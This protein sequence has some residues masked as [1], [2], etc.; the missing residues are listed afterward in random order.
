MARLEVGVGATNKELK[1]VLADSQTLVRNFSNNLQ[2]I[3]LNI[4]VNDRVN[5]RIGDTRQSLRSLSSTIREFK[6]AKLDLSVGNAITELKSL[7][8]QLAQT[9]KLYT[10]IRSVI[11]SINSTRGTSVG[12]G[13]SKAA[14]DAEKAAMAAAKREAQLLKNEYARLN[15]EL[16]D[17]AVTRAKDRASTTAASGSYREAQQ[18]LTALGRAIREQANG[19]NLNNK[20]IQ[21]QIAQYRQLNNQLK[22]FDA[23]MG[24]HQRKVG[25]YG[26]VWGGIGHQLASVAAGYLS[27]QAAINGLN[28]AFRSAIR[29]DAI[30]TSLG[31]ILNSGDLAASKLAIIRKEADRLGLSYL[32][33]AGSYKSFI[34]AAQASN[35]NMTN[36]ESIFYAVSNAAAKLKLS[37]DD[38]DGAFRALQQMISKGT[39]QAEE[40]RGQLGERLPGAFAIAARAMGVTEQQLGKM[41]KAGDV[42]ASD[43][44]PRLAVELNRTFGNDQSERIESLQASV[45]RLS[46]T[47][48][49][50][51]QKGNVSK[52]FQWIVD[53]ANEALSRVDKLVNS[54]S[55]RELVFRAN[56]L[57]QGNPALASYFNILG[58][59]EIRRGQ[60]SPQVSNNTFVEQFK[61]MNLK[62]QTKY[63]EQQ[64]KALADYQSQVTEGKSSGKYLQEQI[65]LVSMLE[66]AYKGATGGAKELTKEQIDAIERARKKQEEEAKRIADLL[67]KLNREAL[68]SG[69]EGM[70]REIQETKNKYEDLQEQAKGHAA[71]LKQIKEH[72]QRDLLAIELKYASQTPFIKNPGINRSPAYMYNDPATNAIIFGNRTGNYVPLD[73]D[74]KPKF[75]FKEISDG[76]KRASRKFVSDFTKAIDDIGDGL[77]T[78]FDTI[79]GHLGTSLLN[80]FSNIFENTLGNKLES[81]LKTRL[82]KIEKGQLTGMDGWMTKNAAW[83]GIG[84]QIL[85]GV[86]KRTNVAGQTIGG[87]ISGAATGAMAGGWIGAVAGLVIGGLSGLFSASSA[88]RQEKLIEQQL[89]EQKKQTALLERQNALAYTSQIIG[90]QTNQGL[91]T[92]VD[93]DEYGNIR[94][95]IEGQDLVASLAR[96]TDSIGRGV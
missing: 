2:K 46:S 49:D 12:G 24:N 72:E 56:A 52:A 82:D 94:F 69:Q 1:S 73:G 87:A 61:A 3:N 18:R 70:S 85:Q 36:A 55:F 95:R 5:K 96:T 17:L 35:F 91:V 16:K 6:G 30:Q 54:S 48:D 25:N 88:R 75:D 89:E 74:D 38:V 29:S 90:Q 50:M 76:L 4:G 43:L 26:S 53:G 57:A 86:T 44:L 27:V 28:S 58:D 51:V 42:M 33:M 20:A 83:A 32:D 45:N 79:F 9:K 47:F 81:I 19:F 13:S 66:A 22:S 77:E 78:K 62:E 31:F 65:E 15:N 67:K 23:A 10:D 21:A 7:N 64:R 80:S 63:L 68:L 93:R 40:L 8:T 37:T 11:T 59:E 84:G 60:G 92:G 71:A 34:G 14:L 41:M 39:V